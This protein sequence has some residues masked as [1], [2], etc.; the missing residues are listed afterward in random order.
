MIVS[1][2]RSRTSH[3]FGVRLRV[4]SRTMWSWN[5]RESNSI[6]TAWEVLPP[7]TSSHYMFLSFSSSSVS[8]AH[9]SFLLAP[10]H[11]QPQKD[12]IHPYT[13][14]LER[15]LSSLAAVK[16]SWVP[17]TERG[18]VESRGLQTQEVWSK[19]GETEGQSGRGV[20]LPSGQ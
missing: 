9:I 18:S 11:P 15:W 3:C 12:S 17:W 4:S 10:C 5:R 19:V 16:I 6:R 1:R 7:P 8:K 14:S 20:S 13:L 2:A